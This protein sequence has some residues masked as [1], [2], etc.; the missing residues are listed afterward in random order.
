MEAGRLRHVVTIIPHAKDA[1]V[2]SL[3]ASYTRRAEIRGQTALERQ[4]ADAAH[5]SDLRQ[6][7]TRY[8]PVLK[9]LRS[10]WH[11]EHDGVRYKVMAA[12]DPDGR[13]RKMVCVLA[14]A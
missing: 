9:F 4:T 5:G 3:N 11:V 8:D 2:Q 6:M 1:T 13:M 7:E 10:G 14:R 12:R